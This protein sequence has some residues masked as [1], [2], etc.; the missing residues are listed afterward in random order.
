MPSKNIQDCI[1]ELQNAWLDAQTFFK[2]R[3]PELPQPFLT[4]TYR[5]GDEQNALYAQG[6]TKP[7]A[8]VT[9]AK[10]GQ[11]PHNSKPSRAFDVAFKDKKEALDWN[12]A[13]FKLFADIIKPMGVEWGGDFRKLSDSPHFQISAKKQP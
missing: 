13:L 2:L 11:S 12:K 4:C 6:R 10:A 8:K 7:G 5:S 3:H 1:P 9:N